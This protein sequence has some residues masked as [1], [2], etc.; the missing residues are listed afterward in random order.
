MTNYCLLVSGFLPIFDCFCVEHKIVL[1]YFVLV[2]QTFSNLGKF[3]E[4][5]IQY[6][7]KS[8][9]TYWSY[10][11][12]WWI[13]SCIDLQYRKEKSFKRLAYCRTS[14]YRLDLKIKPNKFISTFYSAI[15]PQPRLLQ[16]HCHERSLSFFFGPLDPFFWIER[17]ASMYWGSRAFTTV[18][19]SNQKEYD[20][21][22]LKV[23]ADWHTVDSSKKM[24]ERMIFILFYF[25]ADLLISLIAKTASMMSEAEK[26]LIRTCLLMTLNFCINS[27]SW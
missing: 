20:K 15:M 6:Y 19:Q 27:F 8:W 5:K 11:S 2:Q 14:R 13:L 22:S 3:S 21:Q 16:H 17:S 12:L 9:L 26:K 18:S 4:I 1:Q 10:S 24:N 7:V 23:K 25:L